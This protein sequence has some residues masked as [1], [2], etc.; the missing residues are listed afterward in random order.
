MEVPFTDF[1]SNSTFFILNAKCFFAAQPLAIKLHAGLLDMSLGTKINGETSVTHV[2]HSN[3]GQL[4]YYS[5]ILTNPY[6]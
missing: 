2:H 3:K 5:I 4:A 6:F 1:I